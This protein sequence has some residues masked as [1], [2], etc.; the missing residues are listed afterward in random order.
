M[1]SH[2]SYNPD[3]KLWYIPVIESCN[4]ITVAPEKSLPAKPR[5]FYTGGGPSQPFRITGSVT[6]IDVTTG[7]VAGKFETKFPL[8][9]GTLATSDLVFSGCARR[10]STKTRSCIRSCADARA[11]ACPF[12][13]VTFMQTTPRP[14]IPA[15]A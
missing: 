8:L 15:T 12:S 10:N 2:T 9:G 6:A 3:L 13:G 4:R 5:E 14:R 11:P 1:A 7:K